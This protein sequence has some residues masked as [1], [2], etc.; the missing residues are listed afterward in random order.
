[1][2]GCHRRVYVNGDLREDTVESWPVTTVERIETSSA[3]TVFGQK[4][5]I[6]THLEFDR[7]LLP[8]GS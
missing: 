6:V 3:L 1:V 4:Y 5:E 8:E 2:I 7:P